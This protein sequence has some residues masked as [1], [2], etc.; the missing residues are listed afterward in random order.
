M[1][2][3]E[4]AQLE[5][6]KAIELGISHVALNCF[7]KTPFVHRLSKV[8]KIPEDLTDDAIQI[9]I[10]VLF[11]CIPK[12]GYDADDM[13]LRY[14][15]LMAIRLLTNIQNLSQ[16]VHNTFQPS[17]DQLLRLQLAR[18]IKSQD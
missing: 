2:N 5:L 12:K 8:K 9:M 6:E 17:R 10:N 18:M 3:T 4:Y 1:V 14:Q 13:E 11:K 15:H 7:N 16:R